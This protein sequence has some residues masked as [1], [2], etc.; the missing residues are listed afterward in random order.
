M[1][2]T[3]TEGYTAEVL[4][5]ADALK[6]LGHPTRLSI[7]QHLAKTPN[8]ICNDLVEELPLAQPTISRHLAELK[9]VGLIQGN[10]EGSNLCYCINPEVWFQ[11]KA[12][13]DQIS[14]TLDT[15]R[16]CC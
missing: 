4:L 10:I 13:I 14:K 8:C 7:M 2:I 5:M 6:V 15:H 11:V 9:R 16:D 3:K 12:T 1:G